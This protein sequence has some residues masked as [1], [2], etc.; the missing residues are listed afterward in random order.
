MR[1]LSLAYFVIAVLFAARAE[2]QNRPTPTEPGPVPTFETQFPLDN[3]N[4]PAGLDHHP[5]WWTGW[6]EPRVWLSADYLLWWVKSAP[7]S[8][9]LVTTG[10]TDDLVPGA[11]GQPQTKVLFGD[12]NVTYGAASGLRVAGGVWLPEAPVGIEAS[13]FVL[14]V[15]SAHFNVSSDANGNPL[16]A[17]PVINA[18]SGNEF[19]YVDASPGI[20]AGGV[21]ISSSA[22]MQSFDI[23]AA[24]ALVSAGNVELDLLA[25]F[26]FLDLEEELAIGDSIIPLQAGAFLFQ[27]GPADPPSTLAITDRFRTVNRF[28][29]GQFGGRL[30][31]RMDRFHVAVTGKLALGVTDEAISVDGST[32]LITPGAPAVSSPGGIL[33]QPTNIG[34]T[35]HSEFSVVPE[36]GINLDYQI[37][38]NLKAVVGYNILYWSKVARPGDQIDRTVNPTQVPIDPSFG[39]L[40]GPARPTLVPRSTDFWAQGINFGIEVLF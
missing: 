32:L 17:R 14:W 39:P 15:P 30:H 36:L 10:S 27:G 5:L 23:N 6:K 22:W 7:L 11:L 31:W 3:S 40:N 29:G 19:A 38:A 2:A 33:A 21:S 8:T 35:D 13:Y 12:S 25:G 9:P 4:P 16:I 1:I 37:T 26:R 24:A 18:L 34:R 20:S 28:Y